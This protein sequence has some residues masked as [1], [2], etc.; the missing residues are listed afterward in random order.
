[1]KA[2]HCLLPLAR[3][4]MSFNGRNVRFLALE[5]GTVSAT[6]NCGKSDIS[7]PRCYFQNSLKQAC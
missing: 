7:S 1:M 5:E 4:P 3:P 6:Y 2:D